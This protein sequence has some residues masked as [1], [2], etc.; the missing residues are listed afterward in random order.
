MGKT[1]KTRKISGTRSHEFF[2]DEL[3]AGD[4]AKTSIIN[5]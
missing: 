3:Y 2:I 4:G 1:A 5:L